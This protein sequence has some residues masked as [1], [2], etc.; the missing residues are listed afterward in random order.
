MNKD[1]LTYFLGFYFGEIS[2]S[3]FSE[4]VYSSKELEHIIGANRYL[5]I[6]SFDYDADQQEQGA[7]KKIVAD[8]YNDLTS[9]RLIPDRVS[10]LVESML[11]NDISLRVGCKELADLHDEGN[12]FIP[13][14]FVGYDSELDSPSKEEFYRERILDDLKLLKENVSV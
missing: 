4:W 13:I 7:I 14:E 10:R 8:I 9:N 2:S 5:E 12:D 3:E 6:I 11:N 1:L